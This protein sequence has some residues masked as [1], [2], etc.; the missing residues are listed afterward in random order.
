MY[1]EQAGDHEVSYFE[2]LYSE[3]WDRPAAAARVRYLVLAQ[4]RT[5]SELL[6][7]YLRQRGM[8]VP[9]EYFHK[10]RLPALAARLGCLEA[11]GIVNVARYR[12]ELE[13]RRTTDNG[14]F[15]AKIVMPQLAWIAGSTGIAP[16][17]VAGSFD[18]V[19]LMRRHDTLL[20]AISLMRAMSTGQ[21]H[22]ISGDPLKPVNSSDIAL[23]FARITYSWARVLDQER[24]MA[25]IGAAL[26][27]A[28][29]RI[30]WY[31]DLADQRTMSEVAAWLCAG[32]GAAPRSVA[33]DHA[34]PV[35]GDSQEA[36]AIMKAYLAYIAVQ[37]L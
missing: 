33:P 19:V 37:P 13:R 9:L 29:A 5:G 36:D 35:K 2:S 16:E 15:G 18:K 21:W 10:A 7:A 32:N 31:E 6:C 3:R 24:D 4:E 25:R 27:P 28:K 23:S 14:V 34:L 20:Q 17:Q 8:G 12:A 30:V 11:D 1:S 26:A 22:V